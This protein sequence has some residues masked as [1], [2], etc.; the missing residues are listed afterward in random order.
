MDKVVTL[1][2]TM[3]L[4]KSLEK[5]SASADCRQ[6]GSIFFQHS[7]NHYTPLSKS[8]CRPI[9]GS[10]VPPPELWPSTVRVASLER[11]KRGK[12]HTIC[13]VSTVAFSSPKSDSQLIYCEAGNST[14]TGMDNAEKS[15]TEHT[16]NSL[17]IVACWN[18]VLCIQVNSQVESSQSRH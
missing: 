17:S 3:S 11:W 4:A 10:V 5:S 8:E 15:S 16:Q 14:K 7:V 18:H 6:L 12:G 13:A 9:L 2:Q 1:Q